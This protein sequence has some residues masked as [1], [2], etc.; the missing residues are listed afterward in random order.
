MKRSLI[1]SA[2]L[3]ICFSSCETANQV[4]STVGSVYANGGLTNADIVEGL[5]QALTIGTQNGTNQAIIC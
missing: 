1:I 2:F 4:L 5:K 3:I